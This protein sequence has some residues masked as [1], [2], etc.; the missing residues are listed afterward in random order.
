M[1]TCRDGLARTP[2]DKLENNPQITVEQEKNEI[3]ANLL[4][5]GIEIAFIAKV[6]GLTVKQVEMIRKERKPG[7]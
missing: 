6:T 2:V 3:A 5:K 1:N 7:K 4:N